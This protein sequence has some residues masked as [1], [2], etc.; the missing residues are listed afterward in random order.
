M[1]EEEKKKGNIRLLSFWF[2]NA[3][4]K[5]QKDNHIYANKAYFLFKF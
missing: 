5:R 4:L 1:K 3:K 2:P